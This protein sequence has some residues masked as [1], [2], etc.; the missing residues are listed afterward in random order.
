MSVKKWRQLAE[1][2]SAVDQQT[3]EI[4][5]KFKT[6]KINKGFSQLSGEEF[7]NQLQKDLMKRAATM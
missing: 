1:E 3:E 5:Q 6:D 2:K 4:H 7:L